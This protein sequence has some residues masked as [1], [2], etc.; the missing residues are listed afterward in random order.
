MAEPAGNPNNRQPGL[1]QIGIRQTDILAIVLDGSS[2]GPNRGAF[3]RAIAQR[4]VD[5]FVTT[6]QE[7][8]VPTLIVQL[9]AI[10]AE[11]AKDFRGDS[12]SY[13]LIHA[14]D[15]KDAFVLHAGNCL[16]GH[17]A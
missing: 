16:I 15:G 5:W 13:L 17:Y 10:R 11:L 12:A 6:D 4:L 8:S 1:C 9:R 2:S 14:I 3:A 7:I